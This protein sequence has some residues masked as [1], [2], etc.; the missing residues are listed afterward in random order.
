MNLLR[1]LFGIEHE[2]NT[3]PD[4]EPRHIDSIRRCPW[5]EDI[6]I[7]RSSFVGV[8]K[9]GSV[10]G[11][12]YH[13]VS[14][15]ADGPN[16][17]PVK[18]FHH[19]FIGNWDEFSSF[20]EANEFA[21]KLYDTVVELTGFAPPVYASGKDKNG[22]ARWCMGSRKTRPEGIHPKNLPTTFKAYSY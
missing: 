4:S 15:S 11:Q 22:H 2:H 12:H 21:S 14:C 7:E 10:K 8:G 20:Q 1:R 18:T 3:V 13:C 5:K 6:F 9:Y 17:D 19:G 16:N